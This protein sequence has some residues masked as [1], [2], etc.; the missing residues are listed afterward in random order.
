MVEDNKELEQIAGAGRA[1]EIQGKMLKVSPLRLRDIIELT[2]Y[3]VDGHLSVEV[4]AYS[5][6]L[7]LRENIELSF[8]N[9]KDWEMTDVKKVKEFCD[10]DFYPEKNKEDKKEDDNSKNA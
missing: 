3:E 5:V 9:M 7:H 6:F 10:A 4:N 1:I 2:Q 8:D